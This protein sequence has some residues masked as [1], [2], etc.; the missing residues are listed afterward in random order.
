M[1]LSSVLTDDLAVLHPAK[2]C[3]CGIATDYFELKGR[4]GVSQ[5]K[6]CAA[7]AIDFGEKV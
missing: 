7:H 2:S 3:G 6:T 4:A 5:I 1:P